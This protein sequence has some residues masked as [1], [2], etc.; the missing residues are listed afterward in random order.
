MVPCAYY[1]QKASLPWPKLHP[2]KLE[3]GSHCSLIYL[4]ASVG[5]QKLV[6]L[7]Y[8]I[9]LSNN[10]VMITQRILQE[11][12]HISVELFTLI[13]VRHILMQWVFS[14]NRPDATK[15]SSR[16]S[17]PHLTTVISPTGQ[18]SLILNS[19]FGFKGLRIMNFSVN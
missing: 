3:R 13:C 9:A 8:I 10:H 19:F 14:T 2:G 6:D 17:P 7:V 18:Y 15:Y 16:L 4:F 5:L 11:V 1:K 12:R